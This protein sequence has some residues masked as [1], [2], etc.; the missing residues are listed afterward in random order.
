MKSLLPLLFSLS[1]FLALTGFT[2]Q[3]PHPAPS[4]TPAET[5]LGAGFR[6]STYGTPQDPGP[7]YW[8]M[9]GQRLAEKFPGAHPET[10]WIVSNIYGEGTYLNFPCETERG[11]LTD[12]YIK[13]GFANMNEQALNLF[14]ENGFKVWLQVEAGNADMEE[15]IR[16]VLGHYKEHPSV[17]GFGVDVEWYKSTDGPLGVP[18]TDAEAK[19]WVQVAQAVNPNYKL[20]LKHW[21]IDWM[22]PT[23]REDIVFINDHQSFE[24]LEAMLANFTAWGEHF[25]PAPVGYQFGNA[26]DHKWWKP[27]E[28]PV[29]KIGQTLLDEIPNTTALF[30]VDFTI[31]QLFPPQ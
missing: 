14:D 10:I 31:T 26:S 28:D 13:C 8:N 20:F 23:Y 30:W 6:Y 21:E 4:P 7:E 2:I 18:I 11:T 9:V 17:I 29:K 15:L 5:A 3:T 24:D 12:P 25:A 19:R 1:L 22:P 27:M 16:I